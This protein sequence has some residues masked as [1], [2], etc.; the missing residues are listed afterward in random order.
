MGMEQ[1]DCLLPPPYSAPWQPPEGSHL[2][3]EVTSTPA[4]D[5]ARQPNVEE[6]LQ[7]GLGGLALGQLLAASRALERPPVHADC[8]D[9]A[10]GAPLLRLREA[11]VAQA[12]AQLVQQHH[13]VPVAW[14]RGPPQAQ[15]QWVAQEPAPPA[16]RGQALRGRGAAAPREALAGSCT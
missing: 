13:R 6:G 3:Q 8:H 4:G 16:G 1:G 5:L 14:G 15:V 2:G 11:H 7:G 10:L 9:E 12:G